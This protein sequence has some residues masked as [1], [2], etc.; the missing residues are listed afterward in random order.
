MLFMYLVGMGIGPALAGAIS[1]ALQPQYGNDS[2]RY[3][4]AIITAAYLL[5]AVVIF[6][7]TKSAKHDL[8]TYDN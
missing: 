3:A 5:G 8:D 1:D 2:L 7:A 4:I 6:S